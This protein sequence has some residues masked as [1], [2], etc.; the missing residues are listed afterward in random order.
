MNRTLKS[1][2]AIEKHSEN[3]HPEKLFLTTIAY[4]LKANVLNFT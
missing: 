2:A 3:C 1:I 4:N